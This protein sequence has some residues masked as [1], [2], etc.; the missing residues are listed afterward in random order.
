MISR[1]L[2]N[3]FYHNNLRKTTR[4]FCKGQAPQSILS[5]KKYLV[6]LHTFFRLVCSNIFC[7]AFCFCWSFIDKGLGWYHL[8]LQHWCHSWVNRSV[9]WEH[10]F[11]KI[12][13]HFTVTFFL[14]INVKQLK[15]SE[16]SVSV[17]YPQMYIKKGSLMY[18]ISHAF[19]SNVEKLGVTN[20]GWSF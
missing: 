2:N 8:H 5:L 17:I 16:W 12:V 20:L 11:S 19:F 15:L 3:V 10:C 18:I 1:V 13:I 6:N 4:Y 9:F 7:S 14:N